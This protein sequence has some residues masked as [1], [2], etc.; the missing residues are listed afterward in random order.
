ML[1]NAYEINRA[2]LSGAS[3]LASA[4]AELLSN[5]LLP[6]NMFGFGPVM[7]SAFAKLR[8]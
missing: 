3:A 2:W 5:P 8:R 6:P 4:G 1:Y 7:A